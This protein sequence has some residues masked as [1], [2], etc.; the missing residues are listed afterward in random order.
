MDDR[1]RLIIFVDMVKSGSK[2]MKI[3]MLFFTTYIITTYLYS[4]FIPTFFCC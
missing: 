3:Y 1:L 4:F 2:Y